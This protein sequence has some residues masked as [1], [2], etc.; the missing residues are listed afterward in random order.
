MHY[1]DWKKL[2]QEVAI[3]TAKIA[4]LSSAWKCEEQK[5]VLYSPEI[6]DDLLI[7]VL[8]TQRFISNIKTN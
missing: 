1:K 2:S 4:L 3:I 6:I 7:Q 5:A 8:K